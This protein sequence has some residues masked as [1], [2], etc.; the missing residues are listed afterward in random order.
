[1]F[2]KYPQR[3]EFLSNFAVSL[4]S[5]DVIYLSSIKCPSLSSTISDRL[6]RLNHSDSSSKKFPKITADLGVALNDLPPVVLNSC[7]AM[8]QIIKL[9]NLS[10]KTKRFQ[11]FKKLNTPVVPTLKLV[12]ETKTYYTMQ[13]IK[14]F[15]G[16]RHCGLRTTALRLLMHSKALLQLNKA[17]FMLERAVF[18][19]AIVR[20]TTMFRVLIF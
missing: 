1:M 3:F 12:E 9:A 6:L 4:V 11:F 18:E 20:D 15:R 17:R 5:L 14:L 10:N 16:L 13:Y 2:I 8:Q 19:M 7:S